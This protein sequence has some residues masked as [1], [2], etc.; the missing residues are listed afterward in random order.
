MRILSGKATSIQ[1][2]VADKRQSVAFTDFVCVSKAGAKPNRTLSS[3][4]GYQCLSLSIQTL[5][6]CTVNNSISQTVQRL[7]TGM[8]IE[9]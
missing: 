6:L 3:T 1:H 2:P 7:A 9:D 5:H 8:K 4:K